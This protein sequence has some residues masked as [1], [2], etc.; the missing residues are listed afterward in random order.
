M[1]ASLRLHTQQLRQD[2]RDLAPP[3]VVVYPH[4]PGPVEA[5]RMIQRSHPALIK[6]FSPLTSQGIERDWTDSDTYSSTCSGEVTI[7]ITDDGLADSVRVDED[8]LGMFVKPLEE[9]MPMSTFLTRLVNETSTQ[10]PVLY[11][12][13]QD[14]NLFRPSPNTDSDQ[15]SPFR[16]YFLPDITWMEEAIGTGAEAVNLWIGNSRARTSLHHD[17]YEN[18]YHVLSGE[19][20]FLLAAPIEGLWLDQ[21]F[22]PPA[23]LHRT[24]NGIVPFLDPEPSHDVPWV[25]SSRLPQGVKTMEVTVHEGETLYLPNRWWHAVSQTEGRLGITV[26][27]NYWYPAEIR[28]ERYAFERLAR[29]VARLGGMRGVIPPPEDEEEN[30]YTNETSCVGIA[31]VEAYLFG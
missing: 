26:A 24:S 20:T 16:P 21:Q 28:P 18:I 15:L 12:Q 23:T 27:V 5:A 8:G 17:P 3:D 13:S 25:A 9:K 11:L 2:Y 14:G 19:K 4:P 30:R 1:F 6:N 29:R 22:Y 7:A 31:K 10:E